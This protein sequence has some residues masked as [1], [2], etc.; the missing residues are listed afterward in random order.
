[1]AQELLADPFLPTDT[2]LRINLEHFIERRKEIL[3]VR[4]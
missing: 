4:E 2:I 1:M 3:S